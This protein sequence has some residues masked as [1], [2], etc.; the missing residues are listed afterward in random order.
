M[1]QSL[2]ILP[3]KMVEL[4][5]LQSGKFYEIPAL[6]TLQLNF[7][8]ENNTSFNQYFAINL[9]REQLMQLFERK[10][11]KLVFL[12]KAGLRVPI[13][14]RSIRNDYGAI[15]LNLKPNESKNLALCITN[16]QNTVR[17]IA[18]KLETDLQYQLQ[19][20]QKRENTIYKYWVP[21]FFIL[22]IMV[23]IF[24]VIQYFILPEKHFIFYFLYLLFLLIRSASADERLVLEELLPLV[25]KI[26]YSSTDSQLF[27]FIS[28]IFYLLF[29]NEFT[30]LQVKKPKLYIFYKIEI[31]YLMLFIVFDLVYPSQKFTD[32]SL[33][34]I[35]RAMETFGVLIGLLNIIILLKVYDRFNKYVIIG[36]FSLFIFAILGQEIV[37]RTLDENKDPYF[38]T[39]ALTMVWSIAYVI[40]ILFFT[41][42]LVSRQRQLLQSIDY[43]KKQISLPEIEQKNTAFQQNEKLKTL[44]KPNFEYFSLATN[45]G[46]LVFQQTEIVRLEASG[47]YTIFSIHNNKQTLGSYTLADFENK[48]NPTKFLRVHKSHLV[49][50]Q[51]VV[52]YTKGDG[53]TLTLQDGSEI[54]VSRSRKDELLKRLQTS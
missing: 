17:H 44:E 12:S 25:N 47:N 28:F 13:M 27:V 3:K 30:G 16:F 24:T 18:P 42:A 21:G 54:P 31:A 29:L 33:Q 37:K 4:N 53:G 39:N 15:R 20:N 38:Y 43:E 41:M 48:L 52:K 40:E 14:E 22:L 46:V 49:N 5:N 8:A 26:G 10:G 50:L 35:F 9:G 19:Y 7:K 1:A 23:L 32:A 45:K 34:S 2:P 51:Y 11:Y 6:T 36:A